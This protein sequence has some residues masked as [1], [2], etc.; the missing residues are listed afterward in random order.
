MLDTVIQLGP[1]G[2]KDGELCTLLRAHT[3]A[4]EQS[5]SRHN[6]KLITRAEDAVASD[7]EVLTRDEHGNTWLAIGDDRWSAGRFEAVTIADLRERAKQARAATSPSASAPRLRIWVFGGASIATDI[8]TLQ[9]TAGDNALFQVASQF[10]CLESPAAAQLAPVRHYVHDNTQGP[11]AA[12]GAF[13]AALLRHYRAPGPD[14]KP[15]IQTTDGMQLDLLDQAINPSLGGRRNG[16]FDGSRA[17]DIA[18]I[19]DAL[20]NNQDGIKVGLQ[21]E[22]EVVLGANW[23]GAVEGRPRIAQVF[24]STVAGGFYGGERAFGSSF[25]SVCAILLRAAYRGTLL[26]AAAGRRRKVVLTLIGG[27][28]FANDLAVIWTAITEALEHVEPLL[29]G[30]MDVFVNVR[31]LR[32]LTRALHVDEPLRTVRRWGGA[33]IRFEQHGQVLVER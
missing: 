29:S 11:R 20:R 14:G 6:S 18:A 15:F 3:V 33:V 12:V 17:R 13:P 26:A 10:N 7:P 24:T 2:V 30:D 1:N 4:A 21:M 22:A 23:Y 5:K 27:G 8:G 32:D 25:P 19:V 28:V 31:D 16:Y 9:A